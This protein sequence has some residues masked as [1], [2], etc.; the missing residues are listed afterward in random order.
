MN[1]YPPQEC[2]MPDGDHKCRGE[3]IY[4]SRSYSGDGTHTE[5]FVCAKC[6]SHVQ[7]SYRWK[8]CVTTTEWVEPDTEPGRT[9]AR[10]HL[11]KLDKK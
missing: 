1:G 10:I 6:G 4:R 2:P 5:S 9:A 8:T 7:R 3:L 11:S